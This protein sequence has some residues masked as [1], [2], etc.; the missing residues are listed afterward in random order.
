MSTRI[1]LLQARMFLI[2][3]QKKEKFE[4]YGITF[5]KNCNLT[6]CLVISLEVTHAHKDK[7]SQGMDPE[8]Q[9]LVKCLSAT[10]H[11]ELPREYERKDSQTQMEKCVWDRASGIFGIY[12]AKKWLP[13]YFIPNSGRM[14]RVFGDSLRYCV[15]LVCNSA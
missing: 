12:V 2:R 3:I 7:R 5:F 1:G 4:Q 11:T 15:A 10:I 14:R 9:T 6:R 13:Q 8:R